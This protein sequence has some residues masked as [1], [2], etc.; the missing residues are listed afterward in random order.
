MPSRTYSFFT[1]PDDIKGGSQT[2][3]MPLTPS[4][5]HDPSMNDKATTDAERTFSCR[6]VQF[7]LHEFM[8]SASHPPALRARLNAREAPSTRVT[9]GIFLQCISGFLSFFHL[10]YG[11]VTFSGLLFIDTLDA[12]GQI[13]PRFLVSNLVCRFVVLVEI[14]GMRG[15]VLASQSSQPTSQNATPYPDPPSGASFVTGASVMRI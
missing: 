7:F 2:N 11:T 3:V 5:G 6:I 13:A 4:S 9:I 1:Q 12:V 8:P 10:L 15:A 14:A